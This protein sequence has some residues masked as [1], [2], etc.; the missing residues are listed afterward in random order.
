[1]TTVLLNCLI[2][3]GF[4]SDYNSPSSFRSLMHQ[5]LLKGLISWSF[6][7]TVAEGYTMHVFICRSPIAVL[8]PCSNV[9]VR[10]SFG[11][12][13]GSLIEKKQSTLRYWF[14]IGRIFAVFLCLFI[15]SLDFL[16]QYSKHCENLTAWIEMFRKQNVAAISHPRLL[17]DC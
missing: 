5:E 7:S 15:S 1:M 17:I 14:Q 2:R 6:V 12:Q 13:R 3:L 10:T 16:S 9:W 8:F 4:Q 11:Q